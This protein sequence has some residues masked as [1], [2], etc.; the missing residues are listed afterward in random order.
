MN[1]NQLPL[2]GFPPRKNNEGFAIPTEEMWTAL[3]GAIVML[4]SC[5]TL[6]KALQDEDVRYSLALRETEALS[7]FVLLAMAN[8]TANMS[9]LQRILT[10]TSEVYLTILL[11]GVAGSDE[12]LELGFHDFM[13]LKP[14]GNPNAN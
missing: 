11:T 14:S 7:Q 9:D 10:C 2:P 4:R 3:I 8:P 13:A 6:F 12:L 5:A 1:A